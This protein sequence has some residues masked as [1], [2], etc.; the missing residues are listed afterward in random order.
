MFN[1]NRSLN[2]RIWHWLNV[3]VV[4][5]LI[6]TY[7]LRKTAF[8]YKTNAQIL[9]VKLS[10]IGV[11]LLDD[12]A[13]EIAKIFR[14]NMWQAHYYLGFTFIVLLLFRLY[15]FASKQDKFPLCKAKEAKNSALSSKGE[16]IKVKYAHAIFYAVSAYMAI[17]GLV[18]YFRESLGIE[19]SS[20]GLIKELHEWA[21]WFFT[22][23]IIAHIVGVIKAE[24]SDDKGIISSMFNGKK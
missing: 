4:F 20:L 24:F 14:D 12:K 18:M 22:F 5:G 3:I 10:E 19:K 8:N 17:S 21:F 9:Q 6:L 11:V 15:A 16:Y 1:E 13:K 23:F 7:V 2:L